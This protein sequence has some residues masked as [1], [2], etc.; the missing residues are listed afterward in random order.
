MRLPSRILSPLL[1]RITAVRSSG[2]PN[3]HW[4]VGSRSDP[5][6][7]REARKRY[8]ANQ[9]RALPGHQGQS[10]W[11]IASNEGP[12]A[13]ARVRGSPGSGSLRPGARGSAFSIHNADIQQ[14]CRADFLQEL[15]NM[16]SPWRARADVVI[17]V[18]G[19]EAVGALDPRSRHA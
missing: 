9:P 1:D 4:L 2:P 18:R 11:L 3:Q 19:C 8:R 10:P 6:Q 17:D 13:G 16:P 15:H 12:Y 7:A 14:G 5:T